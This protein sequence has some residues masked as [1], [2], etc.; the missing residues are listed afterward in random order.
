[1]AKT[2]KNSNVA[3]AFSIIYKTMQDVNKAYVDRLEKFITSD[4]V[5]K[6]VAKKKEILTKYNLDETEKFCIFETISDKWKYENYLSD[7]L[8]IILDPMT[9][10]IGN[11]QFL[12]NFLK[13][14]GV[15]KEF[16]VDKSTQVIREEMN[17]DIL[18]HNKHAQAII[19]ESKLNGAA[20]QPDQPT[21]YVR[22][23]KDKDYVKCYDDIVKVVYLVRDADNYDKEL[24]KVQAKIKDHDS[25]FKK[26]KDFLLDE[27]NGVL[28]VRA[29][30]TDPS[31]EEDSLVSFLDDCIN[32]V[33]DQEDQTAKVIIEQYKILLQHIGGNIYMNAPNM[34]LLK[35]IYSDEDKFEAAVVFVNFWNKDRKDVRGQLLK[36][37]VLEKISKEPDDDGAHLYWP[38][39]SNLQ[40]FFQWDDNGS[41]EIGFCNKTKEFKQKKQ[42]KLS[43][44]LKN[45]RIKNFTYKDSDGEYIYGVIEDTFTMFEDVINGIELLLKYAGK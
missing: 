41:V 16:I 22:Y 12:K 23:V 20:P 6:Y 35:A 13:R 30:I 29:G 17:I 44:A 3:K 19:I 45:L 7:I 2:N 34:E 28:I 15:K 42:E 38:I 4:D 43:E 5:T 40:V 33:K 9:P 21:K 25:E 36:K 18:I 26:E 14:M 27:S 24:K 1:M 37:H 39:D 10:K 11:I 31:Q 8:Q 32:V